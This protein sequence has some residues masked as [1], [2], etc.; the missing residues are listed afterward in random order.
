MLRAAVESVLD[1]APGRVTPPCP[2]LLA[3]CGGCDLQHVE[4]SQQWALKA[5][6]VSDALVRIGHL[7]GVPILAGRRLSATGYRTTLRCGVEECVM[8]GNECTID[9]DCCSGLSCVRP[10]G[11]VIGM[12]GEPVECTKYGQICQDSS[13]CCNNMAT[14]PVLCVDN[15]CKYE[16]N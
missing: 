6:I 9:G 4:P 12:C 16:P 3:G 10:P 14:P 5:G 13:E 11:S 15:L 2:E 8:Q 1:P 7:P